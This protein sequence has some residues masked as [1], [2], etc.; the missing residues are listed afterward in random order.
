VN[1]TLTEE[2][3]VTSINYRDEV[4]EMKASNILAFLGFCLMPEIFSGLEQF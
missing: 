3:I 1:V 4:L 2:G